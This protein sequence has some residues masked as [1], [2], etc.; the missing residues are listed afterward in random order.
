MIKTV[1]FD[2]GCVLIG[3][4]WDEYI[5]NLFDDP[6]IQSIVTASAFKCPY[7]KEFDRGEMEF[8]EILEKM[9]EQAPDYE[10]EIREAVDRVG[11]CT[12]RQDFAIP[13]IEELKSR[14]Y[15]VMYLSNYSDYVK[16]KSVHAL[17]FIEHMDGGIFSY[18][19]K[20]IKPD[21]KIYTELFKHYSLDPHE[22]VF[23][24]DIQENLDTACKLGMKTILFDNYLQ[25][26]AELNEVLDDD[27]EE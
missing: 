26:Y 21:E 6:E 16:S 11:E 7:W 23:I 15:Q 5:A 10:A 27:N 9:V 18:N 3:F 22:C 14:G 25:A 24:D 20:A 13:W 8:E 17:D 4:P 2:I 1:V 19:V 12:I